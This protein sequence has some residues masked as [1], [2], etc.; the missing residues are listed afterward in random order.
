MISVSS[1]GN[2]NNTEKFLKKMTQND[3]FLTLHYYG[4]AGVTAL[5]NATP[6]DT[7]ETAASWY[8]EIK[9]DNKSISIIWGNTNVV[10]GRPIAILIQYGHGTRNGGYVVGRDYINPALQPLFDRI[11]SDVWKEVTLA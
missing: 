9:K 3:L 10:N 8:Y 5:A 11:A 6:L 1:K 7:G 2:F 4:A